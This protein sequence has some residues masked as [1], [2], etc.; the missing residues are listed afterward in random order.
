MKP[1]NPKFLWKKRPWGARP[2][3]IGEER[4]KSS[5][6]TVL[7]LQRP[8]VCYFCAGFGWDGVNFFSE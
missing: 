1:T 3:K 6:E 5:V 8:G 4:K 2:E 7:G